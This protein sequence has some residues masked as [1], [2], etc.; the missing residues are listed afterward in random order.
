[1]SFDLNEPAQLDEL[2]APVRNE[3]A[4]ALAVS[5][6]ADSLALMLLAK[7][8]AESRSAPPRLHVYSLDHALR[9]EAKAEVRM[10]LEVAAGLNIPATGLRWAEDKPQAGLQE[11]ARLARYHLIGQAMAAD[12]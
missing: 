8:W 10:V 3:P 5:G 2:F 11:A 1:M 6:G 12:G 9:P 7:R 4:L